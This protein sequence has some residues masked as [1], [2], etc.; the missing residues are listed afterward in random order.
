[1]APRTNLPCGIFWDIENVDVPRNC[2]A[3]VIAQNIRATLVFPNQLV[4]R[5][6]FCVCNVH[7]LPKTVGTS[8]ESIGVTIVQPFYNIKENAADTKI[9]LLISKFIQNWG[10]N[11]CAIV[12]VT[13]DSDFLDPLL[14]LKLNHDLTV[15][16]IHPKQ[17]FS[18]E[19]LWSADFSYQLDGVLLIE[20]TPT[21]VFRSQTR[22]GFLKVSDL[23][24]DSESH[25]RVHEINRNCARLFYGSRV[26]RIAKGTIWIGYTNPSQPMTENEYKTLTSLR[27]FGF[28]PKF[29]LV[30]FL[31]PN[32]FPRPH[33]VP[34]KGETSTP[35]VNKTL[36]SKDNQ[37]SIGMKVTSSH[38]QNAK[39]SHKIP[40]PSINMNVSVQISES[41]KPRNFENHHKFSK[42]PVNEQKTDRNVAHIKLPKIND[43]YTKMSKPCAVFWDIQNVG[44]PKGQSVTSIVNQIRSTIIKPYNLSEIFFFCACDVHKLPA[45]V[46]HSL[47]NLDVDIVQAYNE[48][49][50]SADI[51]IMDLMQKFVKFS[52]QD[53]AIILLSGDAD[54]YG[55]LIDLK[56]LYNVSIH[57][58]RLANSCSPKLDQIADYTFMLAN[59]VLKSIK[60]TGNPMCFISIK[61]YP[62]SVN[63]S[64]VVNELNAQA[65]GS[66]GNSAIICGNLIC[67]GFPSLSLAE[68]AFQQLNGLRYHGHFLKAELI[69]DSPLTDILKSIKIEKSKRSKAN[70]CCEVKQL[71]FIRMPNASDSVDNSKF[72]KFC[73]ACTA[74]T[75]SQCILSKKSSLWVVFSF[76][77]HAQDCLSKV[78]ILYPDAVIS[79]P[80]SDLTLPC[81]DNS[82]TVQFCDEQNIVS[83]TPKPNVPSNTAVQC[84]PNVNS[85]NN[86]SN[87]EEK[88]QETVV[89]NTEVKTPLKVSPEKV[90]D[91]RST[92]QVNQSFNIKS[93]NSNIKDKTIDE[94]EPSK[95]GSVLKHEPPSD[96]AKCLYNPYAVQFCDEPNI[97]SKASKP[98]VPS[99]TALYP[100]NDLTAPCDQVV[101]F[102]NNAAKME[103]K[104][105]KIFMRKTEGSECSLKVKKDKAL[106]AHS[107]IQANQAINIK[108]ENSS[109]EDSII[110]EVEPSQSGIVTRD[111]HSVSKNKSKAKYVVVLRA[112]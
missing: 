19:L 85:L 29:R 101:N 24:Q 77:S 88:A 13:G 36:K 7:Q 73:V 91:A 75:G 87:M 100:P 78:Q 22:S 68:K 99:D 4:E 111:E 106:G 81:L 63:I 69:N 72:I 104:A 105:N 44:V 45:N 9:L 109:I 108:S 86:T 98:D 38:S 12:V 42:K 60:S 65:I 41:S 28:C 107:S 83:D 80:P 62:L 54:Y 11:G 84:P 23:P 1:M 58:V 57:L 6:F 14:K 96:L 37:I 51:K 82:Y 16:L 56:K 110:A 55:T 17:S 90:L 93:E 40:K 97:V 25:N 50:D 46:G 31:W 32:F 76:K 30:N 2:A 92:S 61:N 66:I 35:S 21:A 89:R 70:K 47:I 39:K 53:C 5:E 94:M 64:Q 71:T 8:L 18:R 15:Y 10:R 33:D 3:D 43:T 27:I 74:P 34:W 102:W 95:P 59:G 103:E 49:K 20:T 48:V 79:E 112:K 52:G 67:I 26:L